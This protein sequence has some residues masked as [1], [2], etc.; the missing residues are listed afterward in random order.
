MARQYSHTQFFRQTPNALLARYFQQHHQ[1]IKELDFDKLKE[2][3][4]TPIF[5]AFKTLPEEK[6]AALKAELQDIDSMACQG[7]ITALTDE[8]G[9][10]KDTDFP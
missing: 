2:S 10:Y 5:E 3:D 8:A 1:V 6:Q 4:I 7:G 9:F